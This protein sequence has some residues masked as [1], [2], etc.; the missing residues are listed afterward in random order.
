MRPIS[1][2]VKALVDA[3]PDKCQRREVFHDHDCQGRLTREHA[4]QYASRQVDEAFA[5][6]K[7]CAWAHDVDEWQDAGNLDK[8]KNQYIAFSQAT[9]EDFAKYPKS[10]WRQKKAY[11]TQKLFSN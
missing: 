9:E 5:I 11:L 10:D 8:E 3:R 6:I 1:P 7:I 4:L 2:K